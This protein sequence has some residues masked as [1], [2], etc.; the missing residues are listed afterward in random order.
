MTG[1]D[2]MVKLV[3]EQLQET[4]DWESNMKALKAGVYASCSDVQGNKPHT[5]RSAALRFH[6]SGSITAAAWQ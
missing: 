1:S 6:N 3:D 5:F 2:E 4:A